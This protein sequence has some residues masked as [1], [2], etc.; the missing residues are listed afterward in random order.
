VSSL[1]NKIIVFYLVNW[2]VVGE[3]MVLIE[4][5]VSVSRKKSTTKRRAKKRCIDDFGNGSNF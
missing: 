2:S 5:I 1:N 4:L 3:V